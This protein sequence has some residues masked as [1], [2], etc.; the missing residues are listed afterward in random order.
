MSK[1]QVE[2]DKARELVSE[3][4][5][6]EK[7]PVPN[8]ISDDTGSFDPRFALWRSFCAEHEVPVETLPSDLAEPLKEQWEEFKEK[9][10]HRPEESKT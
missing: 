8:I 9:E 2:L 3:E 4:V 10:I 5:D 7:E 6:Q 1:E